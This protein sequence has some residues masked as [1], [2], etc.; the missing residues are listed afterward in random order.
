MVSTSKG[1]LL[2]LAL[3][4]GSL[5][6]SLTVAAARTV[7]L[8]PSGAGQ[9]RALIVGINQYSSVPNLK[10]AV[11]DARDLEGTLR[12][13]GIT[14][15]TVL[16]DGFASRRNFE[17]AINRLAENS[18]AGDFVIIAFAGHGAQAPELVKGSE[19]D[20]MD[21]IFLLAGFSR[22]GAGT[23]ERIVD[24]EINAWISRMDKKGVEVLFIADTCHGGGLLRQPDLRAA[25][26]SYRWAG[27]VSLVDDELKPISTD[28]DARLTVDDLPNVTF[29]SAVDKFSKAPEVSVPGNTTLRGALSYAVA[30]AIDKGKDGVVTRAMLFGAARQMAYQYSNTRQTILTEPSGKS[31]KLDKVVFRLKVSGQ[32][33]IPE[34]YE[35]VRIRLAGPA[36]SHL[37]NVQADQFKFRIVSNGEEADLTWDMSN[38][39]ALNAH[40]DVIAKCDRPADIPAVVD[41]VGSITAIAKLAEAGPQ[42]VRLVPNDRRFRKGEIVGFRI[43]GISGRHL[44]LVGI[45]GDGTLRFLFPRAKSDTALVVEQ[46]FSLPLKVSE[47]FGSDHVVAIVSDTR[48]HELES[49]LTSI[50]GQKAA[51]KLPKLLR[52]LF[53]SSGTVRVGIAALFTSQ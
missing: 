32:I 44:I 38:G 20:G 49:T 7:Q 36:E 11:A 25:G 22:S 45:S 26:L 24:D 8:M 47:P 9:V 19:I 12:A 21:E 6:F 53:L 3:A 16:I 1:L 40:G 2:T 37:S 18:K 48:L 23:A 13:A 43:D 52:P 27:T 17:T 31:A 5:Q 10:G 39:D 29:L 35:A 33:D 41:G 14:D 4:V 51:G 28:A 30:R 50:D 34:Q 15:L 42:S 46:S